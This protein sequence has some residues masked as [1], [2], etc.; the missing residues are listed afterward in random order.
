MIE[1]RACPECGAEVPIGRLSCGACGA[2]LASVDRHPADEPSAG[3]RAPIISPAARA[4]VAAP[5]GPVAT[6][7]VPAPTEVAEPTAPA[8]AEST[9]SMRSDPCVPIHGTRIMLKASAPAMAP[10]VLAA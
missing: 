4:D 2:L 5:I 10:A 1:S 8:A 6:A 3:T 7:E 9:M